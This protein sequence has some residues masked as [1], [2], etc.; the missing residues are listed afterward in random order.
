MRFS[1]LLGTLPVLASAAI[2]DS[3]DSLPRGWTFH[4]DALV[5]EPIRLRVNL[6]E[7]NLDSFEKLFWE[8]SS[9]SHEKYGKHL[10][11]RDVQQML[12]PTEEAAG[13]VVDWLR[14]SSLLT[15]SCIRNVVRHGVHAYGLYIR[16]TTAANLRHACEYLI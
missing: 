11:Q 15:Q 13:T 10:S 8:I 14:V 9:P 5:N 16:C 7:Q 1:F 2:F 6:K 4:R 12:A 3:I